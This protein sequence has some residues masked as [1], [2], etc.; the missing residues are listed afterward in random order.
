[1]RRFVIQH[2]ECTRDADLLLQWKALPHNQS[3]LCKGMHMCLS[4]FAGPHG[5]YT[6][7]LL[8]DQERTMASM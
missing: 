1:M 5:Q 4:Y 7:S 6:S 2:Q 8:F 3:P